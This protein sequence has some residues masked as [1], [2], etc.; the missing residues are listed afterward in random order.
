MAKIIM[1]IGGGIAAYKTPEILRGLRA[2]RHDISCV[3]TKSAERFVA[4]DSLAA[5]SGRVVARDMF[6]PQEVSFMGHIT[7]ARQADLVLI[8]PASAN[9][10]ARMAMG[11]ADDLATTLLLAYQGP[12]LLAPAMN[13]VMWNHPATQANFATLISWGYK[14]LGPV[15]GSTAC[16]EYGEG[17]M[18]D[19]EP[20]IA[21]ANELLAAKGF[22]V[23]MSR[24]G[25]EESQKPLAGLRALVTGGATREAIDPVRFL[26]NR[27]SGHQ[28]ICIARALASAGAVTQLVLGPV[29]LDIPS[30]VKVQY[31]E[32]A[33][34]MLQACKT[35]LPVDIAICAAAVSDW[36]LAQPH[37][38]KI[39]KHEHL[40]L[41]LALQKT[42]D[43]LAELAKPGEDRPQLVIG[44]AAETDN[45]LPEAAA[46]RLRK[47]CDWI[48]ANDISKDR[49]GDVHNQ[50]HLL[51]EKG[52]ESWPLMDKDA[53]AYR[54]VE[55]IIEHLSSTKRKEQA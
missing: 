43:I 18:I 2:A 41:T 30:S 16:G 24:L 10:M 50:I 6:D 40:T 33:E 29:K 42:P 8:A 5:L 27:S 19:P 9:L 55:R 31:V 14:I 1:I 37:A 13:P 45:L 28:A 22:N 4:A 52:T 17:R 25:N 51:D 15:E 12:L 11:L 46:K 39:K 21:A 54:L 23:H 34:D 47:G 38:K 44:F 35:A 32:K 36:Q 7:R 48:L 26:S 3:M 20:L 49:F 53:I